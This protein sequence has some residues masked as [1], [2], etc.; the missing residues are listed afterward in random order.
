[1]GSKILILQKPAA[2]DRIEQIENWLEENTNKI[3]AEKDVLVDSWRIGE[4]YK[5][6]IG[7]DFYPAMIKYWTGKKVRAWIVEVEDVK[8]FKEMVGNPKGT[9]G[10]RSELMHDR[11]QKIKE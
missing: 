8:K 5:E 11:I 9:T 1:M 4:H 3:L 10:F 6:F 7:K 2:R